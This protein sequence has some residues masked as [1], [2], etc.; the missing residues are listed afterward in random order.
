MSLNH[1]LKHTIAANGNE[2]TFVREGKRMSFRGIITSFDSAKKM[3][4]R[5]R[6]WGQYEKIP[7][8]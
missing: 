7:T 6:R 4:S 3:S 5:F 2:V 8:C 1:A